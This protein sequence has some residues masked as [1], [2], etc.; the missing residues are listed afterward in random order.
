MKIVILEKR[1]FASLVNK[2]RKALLLVEFLSAI[3]ER[4]RPMEMYF[5][6]D[7]TCKLFKISQED[8]E[9][10]IADNRVHGYISEGTAFYKAV[11]IINLKC[12]IERAKFNKILNNIVQDE[13]ILKDGAIL[14]KPNRDQ[15]EDE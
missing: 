6:L 3:T 12:A 7:E 5:T 4:S 15:T 10:G 14:P 8:F 11:D 2:Q 13:S 9:Q 1:E